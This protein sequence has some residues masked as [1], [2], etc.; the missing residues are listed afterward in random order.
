MDGTF[1]EVLRRAPREERLRWYERRAARELPAF[2]FLEGLSGG[3]NGRT[4]REVIDELDEVRREI[5]RVEHAIRLQEDAVLRGLLERLRDVH[6]E[7]RC[8]SNQRAS[9]L[10]NGKVATE[11]VKERE[12]TAWGAVWQAERALCEYCRLSSGCP[13]PEGCPYK[14]TESER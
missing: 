11:R 1:P 3:E 9:L 7:T 5:A 6:Y 8:M 4:L 12:L 2:H 10:R 14:I 13:H